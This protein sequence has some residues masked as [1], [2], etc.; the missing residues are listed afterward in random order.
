MSGIGGGCFFFW[1]LIT[2][3]LF[4]PPCF[5]CQLTYIKAMLRDSVPTE[6]SVWGPCRAAESFAIRSR[7]FWLPGPHVSLYRLASRRHGYLEQEQ[8]TRHH[9]I[10][11]TKLNLNLGMKASPIDISKPF[12]SPSCSCWVSHPHCSLHLPNSHQEVFGTHVVS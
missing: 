2:P 7:L 1:S 8:E 4:A 6:Y 3:L 5:S 10:I 11:E 12:P 9:E